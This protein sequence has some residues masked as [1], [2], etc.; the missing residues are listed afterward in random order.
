M[1]QPGVGGGDCLVDGAEIG[2]NL[3]ECFI[4]ERQN[5]SSWKITQSDGGTRIEARHNFRRLK[6]F[7]CLGN[8]G[9][10]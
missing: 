10:D 9:A 1:S 2:N 7:Y 8:Q 6:D 3:M 4:G 5:I